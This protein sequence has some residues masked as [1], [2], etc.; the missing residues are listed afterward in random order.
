MTAQPPHVSPSNEERSYLVLRIVVFI[1]GLLF[2][3]LDYV[4]VAAI[5]QRTMMAVGLA[6]IAVG[7]AIMFAGMVRGIS[8]AKMMVWAAPVDFVAF[9]FFSALAGP[10]DPLF[11]VGILFAV[12]FAMVLPRQQAIPLAI[13]VGVSYLVGNAFSPAHTALTLSLAAFKCLLIG[14]IGVLV[15]GTVE[16]MRLREHD[17]ARVVAEREAV[18]AQLERRV[19]ELQAVSEI[20]EV[21][22]SSLDFDEVGALVLDIIS[23]VINIEAL[24][25]FVLDQEKSEALFSASVGIPRDPGDAS[26]SEFRLADIES[27]FTCL[28]VF[29]HGSLSVLFCAPG[30]EIER[31]TED[32]RLVI[33]AVASE[34]VVAVENSRLYK[35]TRRLAVTDELTGMSNYR[36][37]QQ[38]LDDEIVRAK[39]YEK[40]LSM[41]M[42]DADN[43]KDF[44]DRYGHIAGDRALAE[45]A[46][47]LASLVREVDVVARYGGEEFAIILPETDAAGAYV[48]AEKIRE[49]LSDHTFAD[50]DGRRCCTLTVSIGIATFPTYAHDRESLLREAD[51]ALYRAKDSG[52]DRV[53]TPIRA[54]E[55]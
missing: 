34:F 49:A 42:M 20:T 2:Y 33:H 21:I 31:L 24:C 5:S 40:H 32:D 3:L 55:A 53:C 47:I 23:K 29:D 48:V 16:R 43:F 51:D 38:R 4:P 22:H 11:P 17:V 9:A 10:L 36:Y 30:D 26:G 37:F 15:S 45:F 44:N 50:A 6:S 19:S 12:L 39:R 14:L 28:R 7:T 54:R 8:V 46:Q 35:L 1:S 13:A 27:H 52:K 25:V 18:N 41:L